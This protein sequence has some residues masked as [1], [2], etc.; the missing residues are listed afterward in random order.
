MKKNTSLFYLLLAVCSTELVAVENYPDSHNHE[1]NGMKEHADHKRAGNIK[2]YS[3]DLKAYSNQCR[4]Y[5][6]LASAVD[7]FQELKE[8]C[9]SMSG[10]FK[11]TTCPA[12][13]IL[14]A[15]TDIVR[16][17]HKPDVI[18]DNYYY[19]GKPSAWTKEII[20]RVCGDLGGEL[21]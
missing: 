16:N 17:Y 11:Q 1:H 13:E 19:Q 4:E 12:E 2:T 6:I 15:C 10:R 21:N 20:T 5:R 7:T 14:T 18:Y 8:G 9:E 3:C